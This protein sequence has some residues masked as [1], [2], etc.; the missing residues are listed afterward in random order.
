MMFDHAS[1]SQELIRIALR[2]GCT[3]EQ[4]L[5]RALSLYTAVQLS[6][7]E[8]G[9]VLGVVDRD[10]NVLGIIASGPND[11]PEAGDPNFEIDL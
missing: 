4:A 2:D 5:N 9:C 3:I 8:R 1:A 10:F 11:S 6:V 7:W